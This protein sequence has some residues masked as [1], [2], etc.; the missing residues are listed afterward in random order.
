LKRFEPAEGAVMVR[1][2]T[3]AGNDHDAAT[4]GRGAFLVPGGVVN[5]GSSFDPGCWR[6][7]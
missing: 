6:L 2:N 3:M 7:G 4:A 5:V 1:A